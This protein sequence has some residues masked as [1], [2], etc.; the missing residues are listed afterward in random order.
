MQRAQLADAVRYDAN[1]LIPA[2][3]VSTA[4]DAVLMLG[5]MNDEAIQKTLEN[6]YGHVLVPFER[7]TLDERRVER[8][9]ART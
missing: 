1:G 3:I 8:K 2:I 4:D 6:E 9:Y 5:Y 7:A